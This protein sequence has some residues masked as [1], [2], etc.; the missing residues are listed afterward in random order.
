MA[1]GNARLTVYGRWLIVQR[2]REQ[3][4]PVAHVV[5]AMGISRQCAHRWLARWDAEG[6]AGLVPRSRLDMSGDDV[7][8]VPSLGL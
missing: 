1:H 6:E 2:V 8:G 5:K 7:I 4:W 3:G